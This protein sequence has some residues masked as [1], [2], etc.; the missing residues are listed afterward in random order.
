[1]ADRAVFAL[2]NREIRGLHEAAYILAF[3]TL[4]SQLFALVRDRLLAHTFGAGETLDVFYAAFRVPDVMYAVLASMV[5]LFVL[6]P[7]L[8]DA[9]REGDEAV[10]TFLSYMFSF[11]SGAL[12]VLGILAFIFAPQLV[13]VLYGGFS[14][15]MQEALAPMMRILLFQPLLLGVSNLFAAYVQI[16][17]R[18]LLYAVAPILYNI[19]III[20]ITVLYPLLGTM[21][22]AW[23][24]V[25]GAMLHVGIQVPFVAAEG[26][27]PRF[28]MPDW[29]A[30]G[31]VIRISIPRTVTLSAQQIVMLFLV[32]FASLFAVGS[33]SSFSLA[34]NLQAV[35]LALIGASYS[36]AAFPKLATL[37]GAG[38]LEQYR[39]IIISAARQIIFWALPATVLVVVLRAQIV[40]VVFGS[41]AFDWNAT[42]LTG[43]V[44]A[45]LVVS[46]IAQSLVILLVRAC[47]A[48]G[49]TLVPLVLNVGSSLFTLVCAYALVHA[50]HMG[51]LDV[52]WFTDLM[53]AQG[54][55]GNEILL[56]AL[57]YSIGS[58]VNLLLLVVYFE[59]TLQRVVPALARTFLEGLVASLTAGVVTYGGLNM[60]AG[61]VATDTLIGLL[62]QGMG[63]GLLGVIAWFLALV[64]LGSHDL[65]AAWEALHRKY[66]RTRV[67]AARGSIEGV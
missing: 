13:H 64:S 53:R 60:L 17:G 7:F 10:R 36:V 24:V 35:P 31:K 62:L 40:R 14:P 11:F 66:T 26:V 59:I 19:G 54:V 27:L 29:H 34:W 9:R 42:M 65:E 20:G 57:A 61:H 38:A 4:G 39:D 46:L 51:T 1:M 6:I 3:F 67:G 45:L 16:R 55:G 28:R 32:S 56:I 5:S 2:L 41:G 52:G 50:A 63:A 15:A 25:L 33:V 48:A 23:G 43:A 8:E 49:K 44:L 18:F 37:F 22:L 47:Y 12:A 21:G 30:V 58:F